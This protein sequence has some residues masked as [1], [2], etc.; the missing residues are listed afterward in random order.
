MVDTAGKPFTPAAVRERWD[1]GLKATRVERQTAA[2]NHAFIL[3]KHWVYWNRGSDRLEEVPRNPERVRASIARIGPDTRVIMSKLTRRPLVFEVPPSAPDDAAMKGSRTAES[4][5]AQVHRE[6][7]W[8][9]IRLNHAYLAW[10]ASVAGLAVE[11]DSD[12]GTVIDVDQTTGREVRTGDVKISAVSMHEMSFE[13]GTRDG[14]TARWWCR[15]QALPP[16]EVQEMYGLA[17]EPAADAQALNF[18]HRLD[19]GDRAANTPLTMVYTY[20]ERPS[21]MVP[22][23]RIVTAVGDTFTAESEWTFP[24]DDHLNIR[25]GVVEPIHGQW[26]GHTPVTDAVPIQAAYNA[27]WSSIIEHLKNAG[28][29]R[30]WVPM[31]SVDDIEDLSDTPGEAVEYNSIN[32]QRPTYESPPTLPDWVIRQP[33]MLESAMDDVLSVHAI[34]RGDAP[35]GVESGVAMSILAENDDTPIGSLARSLGDCWGRAASDVLK[36]YEAYV[37]ESRPAMVSM[38]GKGTIPERIMWTGGDLAG[39]TTAVVPTDAVVPR[40]R[41]AQAAYAFNLHD[42]QIVTDPEQLARIA[43]LPDQH[44]LLEGISPDSARAHRENMWMAEG[45][46]RTIE[47]FDD[48]ENHL[49]ILRN[50]M[51]SER[52]ENLPEQSKEIFYLH[53]QGHEMYAAGK[54]AE[55]VQAAAI[56]PMAALMPTLA[57][58]VLPVEAL[59]ATGAAGGMPP[60]PPAAAGTGMIEEQT[61]PQ[62]ESPQQEEQE[63]V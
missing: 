31:G 6:Q 22:N 16:A 29:A 34:S 48:H 8:E 33:A 17:K 63:N 20:Y 4:V 3:N 59:A 14:E 26:I 40:N 51:R 18:V 38:P 25:L 49:R 27:S 52:F 46:P 23:G 53:G 5:L 9:T 61:E 21:K 56:A 1:R 55:Q 44:D 19:S 58:D 60:V 24:W 15:G 57:P 43:D 62:Q 37:R 30:L 36:L 2:V 12:A 32:G 35:T 39:Q 41:A 50:F 47:V 13:P 54:S 10:E 11:W 28:N 7:S 42:R 45:K